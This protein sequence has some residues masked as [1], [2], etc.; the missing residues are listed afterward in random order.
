M[1]CLSSFIQPPRIAVWLV[2][3]FTPPA[4]EES[5]AGDLLEE[6][7]QLASNSGVEAARSWY[8]RQTVK[9]I[10]HLF[11]AGL[12]VAPWSITATVVAG[13][14]LMSFGF[15]LEERAI[16]ALLERYRVFDHH[17]YAYVFFASTGI[18]IGRVIL[19]VLVGCIVALIA[20]GREM[21]ATL[22][23]S[24]ILCSMAA[25]AMVVLLVRGQD[26]LLWNLLWQFAGWIAIGAAGA[27][28]RMYRT[29]PNRR[30]SN[31]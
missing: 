27:T 16:F 26:L 19:S 3:L 14:F 1:M 8:W 30:P 7:S 28:V 15:R 24:L 6:F 11:G 22:T 23:L 21:I 18:E 17:F 25:S 10:A 12:R 2:N 9:T 5:I 4:E 29:T 31:V 13:F 20:K